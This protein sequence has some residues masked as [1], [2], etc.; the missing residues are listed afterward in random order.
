[1]STGSNLLLERTWSIGGISDMKSWIL[2]EMATFSNVEEMW[3]CLHY[4][5]LNDKVYFPELW[6]FEKGLKPHWDEVKEKTGNPELVELC[7]KKVNSDVIQNVILSLIGENFDNSECVKGLRVKSSKSHKEIRLWI[8]GKAN[9][10][11]VK[12]FFIKDLSLN[13]VDCI[14]ANL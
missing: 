10:E 4:T 7:F 13:E 14:S 1:M 3:R 6:I 11:V 8:S 9:A 5:V 12:H 2:E